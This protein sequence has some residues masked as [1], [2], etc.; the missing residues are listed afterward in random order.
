MIGIILWI[1]Y[2]A[3]LAFGM[4][5][6]KRASFKEGMIC[7]FLLLLLELNR[8]LSPLYINPLI[9]NYTSSPGKPSLGELFAVF[10]YLQILIES[11]AIGWLVLGLYRKFRRLPVQDSNIDNAS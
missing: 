11:V 5:L 9:D 1:G 2:A 6:C 7:F 3:V 10:N 4:L 8:Y